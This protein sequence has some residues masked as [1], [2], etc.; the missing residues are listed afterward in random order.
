MFLI[1]LGKILV[2]IGAIVTLISTF[3]LSLS[4]NST[5]ISL[6]WFEPGI[7]HSNGLTFLLHI[8]DI[9]TDPMGIVSHPSL[10]ID[11]Q[12]SII[13]ILGIILIIFAISGFI[14]L[15]GIK[16]RIAA[17]IG[18]ILPLF[19]GII[20]ILGIFMTLPDNLLVIFLLMSDNPIVEGII[21]FDVPIVASTVGNVSLGTYLL[22]AGGATCLLGGIIGEK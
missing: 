20:F 14:Q 19:V 21:P 11:V 1:R 15:V 4:S 16:Y 7:T 8:A 22:I 13:L 10:G 2:I 9:F 12:P 3:L 6:L 18:S 5:L 17:I